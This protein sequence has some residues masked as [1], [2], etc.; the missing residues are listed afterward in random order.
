MIKC[1]KHRKDHIGGCMWCGKKLCE[2]CIAKRDGVKLYCDK[3]VGA[4]G[5]IR[6]E[7]LPPVHEPLPSAGRRF[8]LRNGFLE[9]R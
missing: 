4:L 5:G 6:R 9:E 1:D 3:C 7:H 2:F 8:V